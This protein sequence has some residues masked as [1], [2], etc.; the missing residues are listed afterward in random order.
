MPPSQVV[1]FRPSKGHAAVR[2]IDG[3]GA[4]VGGEDDNSVVEL[5][6][7]SIFL[8]TRPILSSICFM[9]VSLT[10]QS[11]PPGAPTM[12]MYLS[13]STVVIC[14]RAGLYQTKNGLLVRRGSFRS[15]KSMTLAE[16][17]S[18]TVFDRSE[19]S[20][21]YPGTSGSATWRPRTCTRAPAAAVSGKASSWGP[22]RL[23]PRDARGSACSC[24]RGDGLHH[25][26]LVDVG[27][28][29]PL[30]R[31]EMIEKVPE[32]VEA[33]RGWQGFGVVTQVV[34]A[35]LAGVVAE[36]DQEPGKRR[37]TGR[38]KMGCPAVAAGSCRCA[39]DTCR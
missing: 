20:G 11:L 29:N 8:R 14:M 7:A 24:T 19:V 39:A 27:E 25:R 16:I 23:G 34:L 31:I 22:P 35:E 2:E 5:A 17:S 9:P 38:D 33:V 21:P 4:V 1:A 18:S 15:R 32:L 26:G 12:A 13:D 37:S 10:P 30:H 36:I 3:L 28:T 6:H